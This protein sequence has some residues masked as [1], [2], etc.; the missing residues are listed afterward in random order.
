MSP[1]RILVP[2]AILVPAFLIAG[3]ASAPPELLAARECK[4]APA[5]F[6]GKPKKN[7]TAAERAEAEMKVSRL[8]YGRGYGIGQNL[9]SDAARDCY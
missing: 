2:A 5:D 9:M 4:I 3:C 6:V 7:A 1:L 8:G